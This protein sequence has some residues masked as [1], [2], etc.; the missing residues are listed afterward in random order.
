MN[1]SSREYAY[2]RQKHDD[3]EEDEEVKEKASVR[4]LK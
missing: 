2:T 4:L 3:N 1:D